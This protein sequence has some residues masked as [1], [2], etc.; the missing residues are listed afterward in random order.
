MNLANKITIS[1]IILALA[2]MS[3]TLQENLVFIISA[4][5]LFILASLTDLL[6]G[7]IAR[8]KET[9]SD[10]GKILDP[11]AD[12]LLII[13][14]FLSFLERGLV[15]LWIV[16]IIMSREFIVTSLRIFALRQKKVLEAQYFGKHKTATQ[17]VSIILIYILVIIEKAS[18]QLNLGWYW[19]E[20]FKSPLI[21]L[22]ALWVAIITLIS[23]LVYLWKNRNLIRSL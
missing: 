12:K 16:V 14:V 4:L 19:I 2:C 23:G 3:L 6:D 11:I 5:L 1:R 21:F 20:N 10:L 7:H 18:L 17:M 13:G 15:S 22:I 9:I 8:K